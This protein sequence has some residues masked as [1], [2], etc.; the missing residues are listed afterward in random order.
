[1]ALEAEK[2]RVKAEAE[3]KE[4]ERQL[5]LAA[6]AEKTRAQALD[7]ARLAQTQRLIEIEQAKAQAEWEARLQKESTDRQFEIQKADWDKIRDSKNI[8]EFYVFLNKYPSGYITEQAL[9]VVE[10]LSNLKVLPQSTITGEKIVENK[11]R[12]RAGDTQVTK[13]T[14]L[15]SGALIRQNSRIVERIVMNQ[16]FVNIGKDSDVEIFALDGGLIK[17]R[18]TQATVSFD[19]PRV[20]VPGDELRV[21]KK[22]TSRTIEFNESWSKKAV[23][24]DH[25]EI[26]A[27]EE[28]T[29]PAG[30]FKAYKLVMKSKISNGNY[31]LN[32]Y[33]VEPGWGFKIKSIRQVQRTRGNNS[34]EV[35]EMVS[36][37]KGAS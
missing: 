26:V 13:V 10:Q 18:N 29:V 17:H 28:I 31:A 11:I 22:W 36:R 25:V 14:D 16:V 20:D 12:Y 30:T 34:Y 6:E 15:Y 35:H 21:G 19:P 5:A 7:R 33:W 24:E 37:S 8:D 2:D 9:F 1:M 32:T 4:R 23:R 27:Y 3:A